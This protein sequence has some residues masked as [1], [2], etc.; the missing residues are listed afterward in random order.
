LADVAA[1]TRIAAVG[2]AKAAARMRMDIFN[3][4]LFRC[5]CLRACVSV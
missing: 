5:V 3:L 2:A 1:A 4:L